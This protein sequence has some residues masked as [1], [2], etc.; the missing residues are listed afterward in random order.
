MAKT[1]P[2]PTPASTQGFS[3]RTRTSALGY[4]L[5]APVIICLIL[6][7]LYPFVFAVWI[8]FTNREI[9][10]TGDFIGLANFRYLAGRPEFQKTIVNTIVLVGSV[11][12]LKLVFALGIALLLNQTIRARQFWRGLILLPWAMPRSWPISPGNC[13]M[14]RRVARSISS[15]SGW[16]SATS[17]F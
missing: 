4:G 17:I 6:L 14:R 7:V 8:S 5:I 2:V 12:S 11:Q 16:A 13:Y 3:L 1:L 15:R 9:G 10:T